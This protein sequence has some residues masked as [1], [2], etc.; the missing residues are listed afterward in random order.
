MGFNCQEDYM[1]H[2]WAKSRQWAEDQ[3]TWLKAIEYLESKGVKNSL[4]NLSKDAAQVFQGFQHRPAIFYGAYERLTVI[5]VKPTKARL[6][7]E[8]EVEAEYRRQADHIADLTFAEF[9]DYKKLDGLSACYTKDKFTTLQELQDYCVRH[10][11]VPSLQVVTTVARGDDL[12][13]FVQSLEPVVKEMVKIKTLQARKDELERQKRD[14]SSKLLEEIHAVQEQIADLSGDEDDEPDEGGREN[15]KADDD[16]DEKPDGHKD[17][18]SLDDDPRK[19][20][21]T[22]NGDYS[23]ADL[24]AIAADCLADA[25]ARDL[26]DTAATLARATKA[27]TSAEKLIGLCE[28]QP[29]P[30]QDD[31]NT[32]VPATL[33]D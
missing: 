7:K 19:K 24:A 6:E 12:K 30:R 32:Y 1:T 9:E 28:A 4:Q 21:E 29:V 23:A 14:Q 33:V 27:K 3:L 20:A 18:L 22:D 31:L 26:D 10:K 5:G 2:R 16:P 17:E 15:E 11:Q 25:S 8:C 13:N